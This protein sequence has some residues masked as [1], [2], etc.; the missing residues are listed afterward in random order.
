MPI[1][2]LPENQD[3]AN[4]VFK[5]KVNELCEEVYSLE[6]ENDKQNKKIDKIDSKLDDVKEDTK[7]I[8]GLVSTVRNLFKYIKVAGAVIGAIAAMI[9][10]LEMWRGGLF[11]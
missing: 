7:G 9:G 5:Q 11:N 10:F 6:K 4:A 8:V 1:R 2:E 3:A